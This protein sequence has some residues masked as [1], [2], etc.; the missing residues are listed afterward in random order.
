MSPEQD[1]HAGRSPLARSRLTNGSQSLLFGDGRSAGARR[2]RD[3]LNAF[4]SE[5]GG[6][7]ALAASAQQAVRRAAQTSVECELLEAQRAAGCE[8]DPIAYAT[9]Y[10][11]NRR[12]LRDLATLK[13]RNGERKPDLADYI[14]AKAREKADAGV[15]A[16]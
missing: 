9:A 2:Y 5:L 10:N 16:A 4:A 3:L 6:M 7:A 1:R 8:A 15:R 13:R 12:A 11:A 14:A